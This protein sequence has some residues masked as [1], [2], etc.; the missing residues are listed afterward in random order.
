M[1]PKLGHFPAPKA[2][3]SFDLEGRPSIDP[4]QIRDIAAS[5]WPANGDN[6]L[7]LG[8]PGLGRTNLGIALSRA[9]SM[10]GYSVQLTT[11]T[12]LVA[13]LVK[14]HRQRRHHAPYFRVGVKCCRQ[15]GQLPIACANRP[16]L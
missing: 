6:V 16:V 9:A 3:S 2:L 10:A 14:A 11:S 8:P 5:L 1:A 15:A 12:T 4:K 13:E 7:L